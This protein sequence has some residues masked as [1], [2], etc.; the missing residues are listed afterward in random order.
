MQ[1][2]DF[3]FFLQSRLKELER[4][5]TV[6]VEVWRQSVG[7]GFRFG[8]SYWLRR[9]IAWQPGLQERGTMQTKARV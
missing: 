8:G 3:T 7:G 4:E 6:T 2:D 1:S 9:S 5:G